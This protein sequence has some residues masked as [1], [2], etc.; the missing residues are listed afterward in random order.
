MQAANV[1]TDKLVSLD[2]EH[3]A[4][5]EANLIAF[6]Q[7]VKSA[8]AEISASLKPVADH[9]YFVFHD[10]YGYF[11]EAF[12]LNKLGHFTVEPD[13]RPGAK[14]LINIRA[15]L[16]DAQAQ[17]VFSEPQFTP[18]VVNSVVRGTDV[19]VGV[20]DPMATDIPEGPNG[21]PQ[22]LRQLGQHFADCLQ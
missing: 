8:T 9:G 22:Y 14:T 16:K 13:R 20:L 6:T 17:C 21:Y 12:Q 5:Y 18:A 3:K 2:P 7:A 1:I 11:E 15:S 10:G 19:K 4:Q